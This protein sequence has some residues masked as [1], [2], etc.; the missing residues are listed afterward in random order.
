MRAGY[1][2]P[3][4]L[5]AS[6]PLSAGAAVSAHGH[7]PAPDRGVPE[8]VDDRGGE[9][10]GHLDEREL[11]RDLDRAEHARLDAGLAGDRA[12][13]IGRA[14]PG[15]AAGADEDPR[16]LHVLDVLAAPRPR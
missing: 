14:H 6:Q 7:A 16:R 1:A 13:E 12:D 4:P 2:D 9:R 3:A 10:L 5:S 11:L 15:G 8:G